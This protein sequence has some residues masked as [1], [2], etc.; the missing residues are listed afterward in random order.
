[1]S[2]VFYDPVSDVVR[3]VS[4]ACRLRLFWKKMEK[5]EKMKKFQWKKIFSPAAR[6]GGWLVVM[7]MDVPS[8]GH[9]V[10]LHSAAW[11]VRR[12]AD[13][14]WRLFSVSARNFENECHEGGQHARSEESDAR[15]E[16]LEQG[17]PGTLLWRG[18]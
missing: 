15:N 7:G 14:V 18:R 11:R 9:P 8:N 2:A 10:A 1:M 16:T 17:Q 12:R 3:G 13:P 4:F 6:R 5:M